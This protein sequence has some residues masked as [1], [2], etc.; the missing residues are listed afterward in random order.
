MKEEEE[1]STPGWRVRGFNENEK[2][3]AREE[4][5]KTDAADKEE[6][7]GRGGSAGDP[8]EKMKWTWKESRSFEEEREERGRRGS[9]AGG[10]L[11][12]DQRGRRQ[13]G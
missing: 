2:R 6:D 12:G 4:S 3:T 10:T 5:G 1:R 9:P 8:S 11:R 13:T 7:R